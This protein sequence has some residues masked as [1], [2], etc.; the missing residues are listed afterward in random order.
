MPLSTLSI[1][2]HTLRQQDPLR[3]QAEQA[4]ARLDALMRGR[5]EY[6]VWSYGQ[7]GCRLCLPHGQHL[8]AILLLEALVQRHLLRA[9][10][11]C[12]W[13]EASA[14]PRVRTAH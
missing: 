12:G 8:F 13:L 10:G 2:E 9:Y 14:S 6:L 4:T 7:N 5:S 11:L 1:G 3:L